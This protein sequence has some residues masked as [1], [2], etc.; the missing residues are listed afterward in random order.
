[1]LETRHG[2]WIVIGLIRCLYLVTT[3]NYNKIANLCTLQITTTDTKS[4]QT[5]IV[6][7]G[8]CLVMASI[9][10]IPLLPRSCLSYS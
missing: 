6:F 4:S 1:M 10:E 9:V 2:G 8:H 3:N 7:T 5:A